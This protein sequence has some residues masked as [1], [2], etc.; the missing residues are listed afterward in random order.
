M[1]PAGRPELD[2]ALTKLDTYSTCLNGLSEAIAKGQRDYL[3]SAPRARSIQ[4]SRIPVIHLLPTEAVSQCRTNLNDISDQEPRMETL[5]SLAA[6]YTEKVDLLVALLVRLSAY[7]AN[8]DF[9]QDDFRLGKSKHSELIQLYEEVVASHH[10]LGGA[11][12][13]LRMQWQEHE[14]KLIEMGEG[15][16]THFYLRK[17]ALASQAWVWSLRE[18]QSKSV[19]N[20][21]K[22]RLQKAY[23]AAANYVQTRAAA[24]VAGAGAYLNAA[25]AL[26]QLSKTTRKSK[27]AKSL[28]DEARVRYNRSVAKFNVMML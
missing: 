22:A 3:A 27:R 19:R 11:T 20:T 12:V 18:K 10:Q 7:Y 2:A 21:A 8:R 9:E 25:N 23:G 16:T 24:A 28:I 15:K 14:A 17:L 1:L 26:V 13:E 4:Q 6:A 5:D